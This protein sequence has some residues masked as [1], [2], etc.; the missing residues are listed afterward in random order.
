M[1]R[2]F[3]S[4]VVTALAALAS[5]VGAAILTVGP[6]GGG[7]QFSEIQAAIDAAQPD[8]IILVQPGT[9]QKITVAKPLR[10]LGDG[11]GPVIISAS[12]AV[13]ATI[14][15]IADGEEVVLS[16]V[17]I[18]TSVPVF[19]DPASIVLRNDA[20]TVVLHDVLVDSPLSGFGALIED[21]DRV[22]LLACR[23]LNAGT[24]GVTSVASA[25]SV[26][27][28]TVWIANSEIGGRTP[29]FTGFLLPGAFGIS[30]KGSTLHVWRSAIQGGDAST[31]KPGLFITPNGGTGIR[32]DGSEVNLYGGPTSEVRG[33]DGEIQP[34]FGSIGQGG[35][36]LDLANGSTARIQAS[37]PIAGG[38]DGLGTTQAPAIQ[39]DGTSSF[40]LD[41]IVFPTL[42]SDT[43]EV[44]VGGSFNLGLEGNPSAYQLLFL[45]FQS[46]P[47]LTLP[48]V[49]GIGF[50][51]VGALF[52]VVT[53]NLDSAGTALVPVAVPPNPALLGLTAFFQ[54]AEAFVLQ[55]AIAN[56]VL[57]TITK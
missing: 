17:E 12:F 55:L 24:T 32:A 8:D 25:V 42:T 29:T 11:T 21:C 16:A 53:V 37:L 20:G 13:G 14:Q 49:E 51:D 28:S 35:P 15:G 4:L 38:L 27:D 45:A 57:V 47:D 5:P 43:Q 39:V 6:S 19:G 54:S 40:V 26:T 48:G 41:P 22:V 18:Q 31:G 23:F 46:G 10:I 56:P 9:Y 3:R 52:L 44:A 36:G 7:A 34:I 30:A 50:L 33:G 2:R 1:Q